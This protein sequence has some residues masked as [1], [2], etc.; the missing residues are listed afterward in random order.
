MIYQITFQYNLRRESIRLSRCMLYV[1]SWA[2]S[3][4]LGLLHKRVTPSP[5]CFFSEASVPH[6]RQASPHPLPSSLAPYISFLSTIPAQILTISWLAS[7]PQRYPWIPNRGMAANT[8]PIRMS[9]PRELM[10]KV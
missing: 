5:R 8:L 1:P 6:L 4:A 2:V 7:I 10:R 3:F 9:S